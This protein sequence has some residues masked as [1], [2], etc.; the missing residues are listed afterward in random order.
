MPHQEA[1]AGHDARRRCRGRVRHVDEGV[2]RARVGA[3]AGDGVAQRLRRGPANTRAPKAREINL[4]LRR[5]ARRELDRTRATAVA[6]LVVDAGCRWRRARQRAP[7]V[8]ELV[9]PA[10]LD[11]GRGR[12]EGCQEEDRAGDHD[13]ET[14]SH[15]V[16][17]WL[18][19]A[20]LTSRPL[21]AV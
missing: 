16:M 8:P 3:R 9:G 4:E 20:L 19:Q 10:A 14:A 7:A 17:R 12:R 15:A 13:D 6:P 21:T 11:G 18:P 5:V 1:A 2:H